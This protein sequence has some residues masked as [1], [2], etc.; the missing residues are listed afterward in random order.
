MIIGICGMSGSGKDTVGNI[1]V[2]KY[3]FVKLSFANV[4]KD[5]VSII[6]GWS[7]QLLEGDTIESRIWREK[8][9]DWWS[10]KLSIPKLTPRFVLQY[11]GTDI[12]RDHFNDNI[13]VLV[14]ERQLNMYDNVVITDCRFENE[15]KMLK[16][17]NAIFIN[18]ERYDLSEELID[19][20]NGKIEKPINMHPSEYL[21]IKQDFD[22]IINN[23]GTLSE[24]TNKVCNVIN[25][26]NMV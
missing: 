12:F 3:N 26:Y 14:V 15:F 20:K 7:R 16:N 2:N 4:L 9:D 6:F 1:L 25:N 10:E 23:N 19:Y 13:W 24:L 5:I 18:V 17:H 22:Y 8:V 11:I 21:W